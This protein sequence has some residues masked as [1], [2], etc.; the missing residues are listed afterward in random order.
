MTSRFDTGDAVGRQRGLTAAVAALSRGQLVGLPVDS[1]YG[2]AADAFSE[3]GVAA[4]RAAKG[5]ATLAIPVLVP[6][7]PTVSGIARPSALALRLMRA[8]WPGSLT[9][10]LPAQTTL[11][12]SL[13]DAAGRVAVRQPLHPVALDL[14]ERTGPLAVVGAIADT[15]TPEAAFGDEIADQLAVI[16]E[17]G[18]LPG[19]PAS[20]VVDTSVEPPVLLRAG[21]VDTEQL[22]AMCPDLV[23]P[24][25]PGPALPGEPTA[26]T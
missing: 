26:A 11:A 6:R 10:L 14:L 7:I 23:L 25:P 20:T 3:R 8:F 9:L 22:I 4:I 1:Q 15:P 18:R 19:G 21:A 17:G 13:T 12:W 16:I 24:A 5:S 2:I